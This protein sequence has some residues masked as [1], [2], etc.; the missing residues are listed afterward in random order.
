MHMTLQ[1]YRYRRPRG[2]RRTGYDSLTN[3]DPNNDNW[4][5]FLTQQVRKTTGGTTKEKPED[6]GLDGVANTGDHGENDSLY[7][8]TPVWD[9]TSRT[10]TTT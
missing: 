6:L 10:L 1:R 8:I 9:E 2:R 5:A 4:D 7:T 3:P